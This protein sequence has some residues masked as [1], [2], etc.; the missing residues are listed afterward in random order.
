MKAL[1]IINL[2]TCG[3][4]EGTGVITIDSCDSLNDSTYKRLATFF[5]DGLESVYDPN[6]IFHLKVH[7]GEKPR[8]FLYVYDRHFS[9]EYDKELFAVLSR[10][11][12]EDILE[13]IYIY[14]IE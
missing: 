12:G 3:S 1:Q 5:G 7:E 4:N 6:G 13:L 11:V 10:T 9:M 2:L 14:E 8:S